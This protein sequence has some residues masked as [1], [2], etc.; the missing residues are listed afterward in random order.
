MVEKTGRG[1]SLEP[2]SYRL[3]HPRPSPCRNLLSGS[4][5]KGTEIK[6]GF[7]T[8]IWVAGE[9]GGAPANHTSDHILWPQEPPPS[10]PSSPEEICNPTFKISTEL[11]PSQGNTEGGGTGRGLGCPQPHLLSAP[12]PGQC[13][14]MGRFPLQVHGAAARRTNHRLVWPMSGQVS[15]GRAP[16]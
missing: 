4:L 9:G 2:C 5:E 3:G 12:G 14:W 1:N 6:A 10:T 11:A 8:L 15:T 7:L 13:V 16:G